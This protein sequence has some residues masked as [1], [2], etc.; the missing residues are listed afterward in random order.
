MLRGGSWPL[1]VKKRN[2]GKGCVIDPS[3]SLFYR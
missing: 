2:D 1:F 3:F